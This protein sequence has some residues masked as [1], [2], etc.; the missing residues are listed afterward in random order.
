MATPILFN[1]SELGVYI[2]TGSTATIIG[3]SRSC[4]LSLSTEM[5]DITTKDSVGNWGESM[6][7]SKSWSM[8]VEGLA[9]WNEQSVGKMYSAFTNRTLL[10]IQLKR[11]LGLTGEIQFT[12]QAWLESY[13][14]EGG[15]DEAV[16][17]SISLTGCGALTQTVKV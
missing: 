6:P 16:T 9:M 12:G 15:Q 14:L 10:D 7:T 13:D 11:S 3:M 5:V 4:S 1:G 8:S 2:G 17:Y